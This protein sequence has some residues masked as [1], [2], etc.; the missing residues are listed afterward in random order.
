MSTDHH[1]SELSRIAAAEQITVAAAALARTA[2]A[3]G[4]VTLLAPIEA[5]V[6]EAWREASEPRRRAQNG[7]TVP[8]ET[9]PEVQRMETR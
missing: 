2:F 7:A 8:T 3:S 5:V 1:S 9:C 6:L 4:L